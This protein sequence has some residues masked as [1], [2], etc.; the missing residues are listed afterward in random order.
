MAEPYEP[1]LGPSQPGA[2]ETAP[3]ATIH[4]H[5]T[6]PASILD[7]SPLRDAFNAYIL[8]TRQCPFPQLIVTCQGQRRAFSR[9]S[10]K[11][12][13]YKRAAELF[14]ARFARAED[15]VETAPGTG[16]IPMPGSRYPP[17]VDLLATFYHADPTAQ[18]PIALEPSG[19]EDMIGN[20]RELEVV[21]TRKMLRNE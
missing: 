20:V 17:D 4:N 16:W 15:Y 3:K 11:A 21:L 1:R 7:L 8:S 13:G 14:I 2:H 5:I 10:L 9:G 18:G 12:M 6:Q 19:W